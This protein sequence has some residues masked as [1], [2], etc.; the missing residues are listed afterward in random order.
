MKLSTKPGNRTRPLI[1]HL[2]VPADG[3]GDAVGAHLLPLGRVVEEDKVAEHGRET[4]EADTGHEDDHGVLEVELGGPAVDDDE[5]LEAVGLDEGAAVLLVVEG[6][7]EVPAVVVEDAEL[8]VGEA[9][10]DER[11]VEVAVPADVDAW[12]PGDRI[13][14]CA[15]KWGYW[16]V[17]AACV[18]VRKLSSF[19]SEQR[20]ILF[21]KLAGPQREIFANFH[22]TTSFFFYKRGR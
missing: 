12:K 10:A 17:F 5:E 3:G 14:N 20:Y 18:F 2:P 6:V 8:V 4:E 11:P 22:F 9:V 15:G 1:S 16:S 13:T 19:I 7:A 21:A